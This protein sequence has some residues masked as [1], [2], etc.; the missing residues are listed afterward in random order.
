MN[1]NPNEEQPL[2]NA[3]DLLMKS[4]TTLYLPKFN[5]I[6]R[7]ALDQQ[8]SLKWSRNLQWYASFT[9]SS[10]KTKWW[11]LEELYDTETTEE[12]RPSAQ[13]LTKESQGMGFS[14][15]AQYAKNVGT[16]IQCG[17]CEIQNS[18]MKSL[19]N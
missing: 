19:L 8:S 9:R 5:P 7:N 2:R 16:V 14:P 11:K 17:E 15:S 12:F 3:F 6:P 10:S 18:I 1:G 4:S 13:K